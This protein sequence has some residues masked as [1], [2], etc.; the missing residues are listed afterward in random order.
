[1]TAPSKKSHTLR[2]DAFDALCH[3]AV[4]FNRA[5]EGR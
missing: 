2:V 4:S 5:M 3:D 1:M